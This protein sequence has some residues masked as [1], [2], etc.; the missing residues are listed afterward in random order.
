MVIDAQRR[1]QHDVMPPLTLMSIFFQ[2]NAYI[3]SICFKLEKL[4]LDAFQL[5][6]VLAKVC[7]N[8]K[9]RS[10]DPDGRR[11]FFKPHEF[12]I[13]KLLIDGYGHRCLEKTSS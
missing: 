11:D 2:V 1:H 9:I 13:V 6:T 3:L 12:F 5:V 8:L 7:Y 10:P 4:Q